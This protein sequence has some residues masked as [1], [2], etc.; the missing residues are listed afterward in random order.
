MKI[1]KAKL[2]G[3]IDVEFKENPLDKKELTLAKIIVIKPKDFL[4]KLKIKL[5]ESIDKLLN[6]QLKIKEIIWK[7]PSETTVKL[8]ISAPKLFEKVENYMKLDEVSVVIK[9]DKKIL[10]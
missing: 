6:K 5:P 1:T 10:K 3:K 7:K 9:T 2:F 4:G 8:P